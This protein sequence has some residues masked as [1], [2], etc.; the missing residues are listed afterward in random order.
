MI[1]GKAICRWSWLSLHAGRLSGRATGDANRSRSLSEAQVKHRRRGWAKGDYRSFAARS[2]DLAS[3]SPTS[4]AGT[5]RSVSSR[6][7][8][9]T[10]GKDPAVPPFHHH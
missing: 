9:E 4:R 7:K 10:H 8:H 6:M 2:G 3:R 1:Q 5:R